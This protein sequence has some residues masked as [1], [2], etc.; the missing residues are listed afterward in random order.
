MIFISMRLSEVFLKNYLTQ[1]LPHDFK[2]FFFPTTTVEVWGEGWSL[3]WFSDTLT[4]LC[5][6]RI[7]W[8]SLT[9]LDTWLCQIFVIGHES[10][11]WFSLWITFFFIFASFPWRWRQRRSPKYWISCLNRRDWPLILS[12]ANFLFLVWRVFY[13]RP[14]F[15]VRVVLETA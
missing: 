10:L 9:Q 5:R 12:S 3:G 6:R 14:V 7:G 13:A 8:T 2:T 15:S 11:W 4:P 1:H